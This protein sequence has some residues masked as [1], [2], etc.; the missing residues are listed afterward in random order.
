MIFRICNGLKNWQLYSSRRFC[1]C[2]S[3]NYSF[4]DLYQL[5]CFPCELAMNKWAFIARFCNPPSTGW[6]TEE[7]TNLFTP[8]SIAASAICCRNR[9]H[10]C[11]CR[12]AKC[13]RSRKNTSKDH[14]LFLGVIFRARIAAELRIERGT[15]IFT[16]WEYNRRLIWLQ[17]F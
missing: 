11:T 13:A 7:K 9:Q 12:R 14:A 2:S 3:L 8:E 15:R 5:V 17:T 10:V 1:H 4:C 6:M 16:E